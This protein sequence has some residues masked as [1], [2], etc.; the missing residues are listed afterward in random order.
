MK[1]NLKII[2]SVALGIIGV[3]LVYQFAIIPREEAKK[4]EKAEKE[5]FFECDKRWTKASTQ[6]LS[7][8]THQIANSSCQQRKI[9]QDKSNADIQSGNLPEDIKKGLI[10]Y[11]PFD[12]FIDSN[13]Y[14]YMGEAIIHDRDSYM[15]MCKDW[16]LINIGM[17]P[18]KG[19]DVRQLRY[20]Y[21]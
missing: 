11:T 10:D 15:N 17:D 21:H 9:Q 20:H 1:K 5:A 3:F 12:F 14:C 16:Y 4:F 19:L 13:T 8:A 2:T 18:W 6:F 7:Q